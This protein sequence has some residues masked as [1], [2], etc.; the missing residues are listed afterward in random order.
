MLK[1]IVSA[2]GTA[3]RAAFSCISAVLS[4]PGKLL[5]A[6]FGGP[7]VGPPAGDSPAVQDLAARVAAEDAKAADNWK[8]ISEAMWHWLMDSLIADGP[9]AMPSWLPR[10]I[11]EWAPGL[12]AAEAEKLVS[13]DKTALE[14]HLRGLYA[15]EGVR[16]V[17]RL[18]P[19]ESWP[20]APLYVEPAPGWAAQFATPAPSRG[21]A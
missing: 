16:K 9:V 10:S 5:G 8:K 17:Q 3:L 14:A 12:T 20:P 7:M 19:A 4:L 21:G 18:E 11:K 13:V 2:I 1:T 6:A 15:V